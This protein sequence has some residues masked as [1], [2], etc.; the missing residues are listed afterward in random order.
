MDELLRNYR[1]IMKS[2]GV[3]QRVTDTFIRYLAQVLTGETGN[4]SNQEITPPNSNK[5]INYQQL[6]DSSTINLGKLAV[7]KL[8]GG[9]GTTMGLNKAKSLIKIKDNLNFLDITLRQI[10][11]LNK[12]NDCRVPLVLMNSFNTNSDTLEYLSKCSKELNIDMPLCFIQSKYPRVRQEDYYPFQH[13]Y[14]ETYNWNPPGHGDI[15]QS[16][17]SSGILKRLL[18]KGIEYIFISNADNLGAYVDTKIFN[19]MIDNRLPFLMEVCLRQEVDKKGGH[20]AQ[21]SHSEQKTCGK[22]RNDE[23]GNL[24]LREVA[25][26]PQDELNQFQ[27]ISLYRYFNTNNIWVNLK[28]LK[29]HLEN[30]KLDLP[31]IVNKKTIGGTRVIQIETAMGAAISVFKGSKALIVPRLRFAPVKKTSDLL[32]IRSDAYKLNGNY[33]TVLNDE[34]Q[35]VP[36]VDLDEKYYKSLSQLESHFPYGAPS[37]KQCRRLKVEGDITF[38]ENIQIIGSVV[39]KA[40]NARKIENMIIDQNIYF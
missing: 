15:Y 24:I 17:Y 11:V 21:L 7:V 31:L 23:A 32:T 35:N 39:L 6:D 20:L 5:L 9:L 16:V 19:Y 30:E 8:N 12:S 36:L 10:N 34:C 2:A 28:E 40:K 4:L 29:T 33:I 1:L 38:G 18:D 22:P 25:Q 37:L 26:C 27:D 14:D 13:P 3:D